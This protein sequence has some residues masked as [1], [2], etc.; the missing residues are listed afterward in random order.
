LAFITPSARFAPG[1]PTVA[2]G[3]KM[4]GNEARLLKV[5]QSS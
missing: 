1:E 3:Q 4:P 5:L 2:A